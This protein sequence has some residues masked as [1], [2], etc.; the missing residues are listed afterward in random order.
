VSIVMDADGPFLTAWRK[1]DDGQH[2][3]VVYDGRKHAGAPAVVVFVGP[4][5]WTYANRYADCR[6]RDLLRP[7]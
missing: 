4:E 5:A 3:G 6:N 1:R 2:V 7:A